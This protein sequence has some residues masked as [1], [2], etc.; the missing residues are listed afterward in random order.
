MSDYAD[1]DDEECWK[2]KSNKLIIQEVYCKIELTNELS[3]V[4]ILCLECNA[5]KKRTYNSAFLDDSI[6]RTSI[7][8]RDDTE[9][10]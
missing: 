9:S 2:C 6:E 8:V 4:N 3:A 7:F 1:Y 10:I 5:K